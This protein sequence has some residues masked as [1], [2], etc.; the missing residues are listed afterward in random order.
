VLSETSDAG[1]EVSSGSLGAFGSARPAPE[2]TDGAL[3]GAATQMTHL[4]A[5]LLLD[6]APV[7]VV[8]DDLVGEPTDDQSVVKVPATIVV[9]VGI[10]LAMT[11]V[12]GIVPAPI[13]DFAHKATLLFLP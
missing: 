3:S 9:A 11:V 13:V 10:C 1:E 6:D 7:V 4:N 8:E 5:G 12:F 2:V